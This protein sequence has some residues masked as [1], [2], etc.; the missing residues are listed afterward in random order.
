MITRGKT[1]KKTKY[2]IILEPLPAPNYE[3][4]LQQIVK[5]INDIMNKQLNYEM[6]GKIDAGVFTE[7]QLKYAYEYAKEFLNDSKIL[8]SEIQKYQSLK[9]NLKSR[10]YESSVDELIA[11]G[12]L[13]QDLTEEEE[14]AEADKNTPT[15]SSRTSLLLKKP[16][17][18]KFN[19]AGVE[20]LPA[21][22]LR[23]LE[24]HK[25]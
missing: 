18:T 25:D 17:I 4:E 8:Q 6:L 9:T 16:K 1:R 13:D 14:K 23:I 11:E 3:Y 12:L 22:Q 10:E 15:K 19:E 5:S 7:E 20:Q 24:E 2:P 21:Q